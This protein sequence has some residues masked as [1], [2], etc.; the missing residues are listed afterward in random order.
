MQTNLIPNNI[1]PDN[2]AN[3]FESIY[4]ALPDAVIFMDEQ[5]AIKLVNPAFTRL[6]QYEADEVIGKSAQLIYTNALDFYEQGQQLV[7]LRPQEELPLR[8]AYFRR[9]PR[10]RISKQPAG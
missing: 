4:R 9:Q 7:Q 10:R 6:L 1:N 2:I 5:R 8:E 3:I